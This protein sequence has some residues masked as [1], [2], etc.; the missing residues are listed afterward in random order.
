MKRVTFCD[1]SGRVL[2]TPSMP[3][4]QVPHQARPWRVV[5]PEPLDG[6]E[7]YLDLSGEVPVPRAREDFPA[8]FD[9]TRI[10]ADGA[11]AATIVLPGPARVTVSGPDGAQAMPVEDGAFEFAA[12]VPGDYA[13]T[14]VAHPRWRDLRT[15]ITAE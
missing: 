3:A 5:W 2:S 8:D 6:A 9:K 7:T 4:D 15:T 12:A 13:I 10:A 14:I 11:D 1:L